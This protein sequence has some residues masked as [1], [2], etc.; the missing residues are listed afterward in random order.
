MHATTNTAELGDEVT[1]VR[2]R[3]LLNEGALALLAGLGSR[4]GWLDALLAVQPATGDVVARA[5]AADEARVRAWLAALVAGRLVEYDG[6]RACYTTTPELA[7]FLGGAQG[8]AY[9]RALGELVDL[10]AAL[11]RP[12]RGDAAEP[13]PAE[14]LALA[15][16]LE[17]RARAGAAVL[18]LGQ[19]AE[20]LGRAFS[21]ALPASRVTAAPR[22]G[23]PRGAAGRFELALALDDR[24][25]GARA[26]RLHGALAPGGGAVLAVS[27]LS[28]SP[29][30]DALHPLGGFLLGARALAS[31]RARAARGARRGEP[32]LA[33]RLAAVGFEVSALARVPSDPFRDYLV[34]HK[35]AAN[36]NP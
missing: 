16:G 18:I 26:A 13:P 11:P 12:A 20:A 33:A 35:P 28:D 21:A 3:R 8:R 34:V 17:A 24:L 32:P 22:G 6:V 1:L 31:S 19:G 29:A 9:R 23:V 2:L 25:G 15:P 10:A 14:L 4:A 5:A 36:T 27:A 7:R 30:D